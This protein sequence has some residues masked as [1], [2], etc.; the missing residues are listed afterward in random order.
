[1]RTKLAPSRAVGLLAA[2]LP[3][4]GSLASAQS[5][6]VQLLYRLSAGDRLVY[7]EVFDREGKSADVSFHSRMALSSQVVVLDAAA[8]SSLAGVQRNRLS[9]DLLEY[10][11]HGKDTLELQ[12][13]GFVQRLAARPVR[14]GDANVFSG[15]GEPMLAPQVLREANSKLL[16]RI[17]EIMPLPN[18]AVQPGSE[19]DST[20]FNLHLR[21][22]RFE[23]VGGES[24]AVIADTGNRKET[25][26]EFTFCPAAGHLTRL[27]F[28]GHYQEFDSAIHERVTFELESAYQH[29]TVEAWLA[30][31]DTRVAVLNALLI[32][33]NPLPS[34]SAMS[35]VLRDGTHDAQALALAV[36]YQRKTT[37]G[38]ELLA[39]LL[40]SEDE[41]VKRLANR[42]TEAPPKPVE[43]P[44]ELPAS[45]YRRERPGTT[46]RGMSSLGYAGSPYMIHVPLDYRGDQPF[47]LIVYLSGGGGLAFDAANRTGSAMKH[48][49]YLLLFPHAGGDLWWESKPTEMAHTLL[50]EILRTYNVDTNRVYLVG[51][52]NGGTAALE[53]GTRWPDRFAAVASLMGAGLDTPSRIALPL[54]NLRDV[55]V[56][57]LHGDKD[58]VIP[59]SSS[60]TTESALR[61]TKPRVSPELHILKGRVHD[62]SLEN[63]EDFT[64][65]F[66]KRY[67]REPF[68]SAV[69]AK[70][71][72]PRY[73]R[74]YWVEVT[75]GNKGTAEVEARILEGNLIDVDAKNVKKLK[76]LLRPELFSST[77]AVRVR[78]NGKEQP[79]VALKRDCTLFQTSAKEY[80]DSFLGYTDEIVIDVP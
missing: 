21:V 45:T 10:R 20:I 15:A 77:G 6:P 50:V 29:E 69:T 73:P 79:P 51:W 66:L 53:Y 71:F 3:L 49:G 28:E 68:P 47:P 7:K 74:Q 67:G 57:F 2:V 72:D 35:E 55:P 18:S 65:P 37:P 62:I 13:P 58:P 60:Y 23:N 34:A 80:A 78:V 33:S 61:R 40:R 54:Q 4:L 59:P 19:W 48:A 70:F 31:N 5:Q 22:E 36:Y 32:S 24:C 52:S 64:Q 76:L 46:L 16:Y 39:P 38:T 63:D 8:G 14:F 56:L 75:E 12:K 44:C 9:A 43:Q 42:F 11:D 17:Q 25:H 26:L 27:E 1:M 41:E 30:N